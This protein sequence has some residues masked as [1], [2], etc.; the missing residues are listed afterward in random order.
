MRTSHTEIGVAEHWVWEA[1]R[2]TRPKN[3]RAAR[4][5]LPAR[6]DH[7]V[8]AHHSLALRLDSA[9]PRGRH[10]DLAEDGGAGG[11]SNAGPRGG[12]Y[13]ERN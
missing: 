9:S 6:A 1:A 2:A 3:I 5:H 8:A 10:N 7:F 12:T 11:F 4:S 13:S